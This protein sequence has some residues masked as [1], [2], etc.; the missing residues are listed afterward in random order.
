MEAAGRKC[1][2]CG[3]DK[4]RGQPVPVV[5]DHINGNADD[6]RLVN[7]R[8]VCANCD[9]LLPDLQRPESGQRSP[10]ASRALSCG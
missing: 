7:L 9:A 2:I 6:N 10:C 5:M 4:W 1:A 8:L 3:I